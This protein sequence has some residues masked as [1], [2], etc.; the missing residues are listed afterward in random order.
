MNDLT[1]LFRWF[2]CKEIMTI[3]SLEIDM[4]DGF[5]LKNKQGLLLGRFETVE[6]LYFYL[7][8]YTSK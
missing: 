2:R 8:G 4:K 1:I 3:H 6:Q 7:L 5:V